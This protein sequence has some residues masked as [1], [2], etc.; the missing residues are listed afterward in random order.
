MT[1]K[2]H[3]SIFRTESFKNAAPSLWRCQRWWLENHVSISRDESEM[4][5]WKSFTI[6]VKVPEMI[7]LKQRYHL[8]E[9]R[10]WKTLHH[11]CKGGR[12]DDSKPCIH[13][14][15]MRA[16][17]TLHH[18]CKGARDDDLKTMYPSPE[19]NLWKKLHHLQEMRAWKT[20]N[21]LHGDGGSES[22]LPSPWRCELEK[23]VSISMEMVAENLRHHLPRD[24]TL[25]FVHLLE[26]RS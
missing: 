9:M 19:M 13:L 26:M 7:A 3:V 10:A 14:Q 25:F 1:W 18:L 22:E 24:D 15:E 5:I 12:D 6:S 11:L 17:K 8:Q 23:R 2:K 20:G 4:N 21:H 16:W